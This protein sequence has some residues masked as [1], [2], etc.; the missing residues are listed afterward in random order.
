MNTPRIAVVATVIASMI[1]AGGGPSAMTTS[2]RVV[3]VGNSDNG[4]G[5]GSGGSPINNEDGD[6]NAQKNTPKSKN[7]DTTKTNTKDPGDGSVENKPSAENENKAPAEGHSSPTETGSKQSNNTADN[8]SKAG[9]GVAGNGVTPNG[10][11]GNGV[12]PNSSALTA[13]SAT[14]TVKKAGDGSGTVT[15]SGGINCGSK[16]TTTVASG[17]TVSLSAAATAG[18]VFAGWSGPCTGTG[19]CSFKPSSNTTVT[20]TF[21][22]APPPGATVTVNKAGDGSG[23]VTSN[24]GGINCGN[25]CTATI[26]A[27]STITLTAT[28]ATGS[29]FAGWSGPCTGSSCSFK[30]SSNTT[31]TATFNKAP[32]PSATVT[33]NKAGDGSG[34]VTSNVGGIN[35]GSTCTATFTPPG[36]TITLTATAASGSTFA[37]W[38]GPCTGTS[39]CFFQAFSDTTVTATFKKAATPTATLGVALEYEFGSGLAFVHSS[40]A[41]INCESDCSETYPVGSSVTLTIELSGDTELISWSGA[42]TGTALTCTVTMDGDKTATA[43]FRYTGEG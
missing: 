43:L 23:T 15:G 36:S 37:G 40:P 16:C 12:T 22:K 29:T 35:C 7:T 14:I 8:K 2:D 21:N 42:C 6:K 3:L 17:S 39:S 28:A 25:T 38:S 24:I 26:P 5:D 41:G 19:S 1:F 11:A 4:E 30:P 32:P 20:A 10:V 18:S 33:V 34:T 27:G 13:S 9:N 31:V